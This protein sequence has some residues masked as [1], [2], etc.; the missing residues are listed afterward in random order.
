[1]DYLAWIQITGFKLLSMAFQALLNLDQ[2]PLL[3]SC[4]LP[5]AAYIP[6]S[7][8]TITSHNLSTA[9]FSSLHILLSS[10]LY[11]ACPLLVTSA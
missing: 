3:I 10:S 5:T 1:M 4:L 7:W 11:F 9:A 8:S 2:D 6:H